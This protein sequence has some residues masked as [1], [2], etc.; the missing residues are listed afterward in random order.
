M[1]RG[2]QGLCRLTVAAPQARGDFAVPLDTPL[3]EALPVLLQHLPGHD[4]ADQRTWILQRLGGRALSM[5]QTPASL[6]LRDGEVLHLRPVDD[7]LSPLDFDDVVDAV[8]TT[9]ASRPDRWRP[10]FSRY[11]LLAMTTCALLAGLV[12][13]VMSDETSMRTAVGLVVAVGLAGG[14]VASVRGFEDTAV[15]AVLAVA[16]MGFAAVGAGSLPAALLGSA[17]GGGPTALAAG[18]AGVV[19][20]VITGPAVARSTIALLPLGTV[21]AATAVAGLLWTIFGVTPGQAG[22]VVGVTAFL[23]WIAAPTAALRLSR[24][25]VPHLP[26][27]AQELQLDIA[28]LPEREAL[29][30]AARADI[31]LAQ[32]SVALGT[33]CLAATVLVL[34][35]PGWPPIVLA[36]VHAAGLLLRS[37][38][39]S[40]MWQRAAALTAGAGTLGVVLV[41]LVDRCPAPWQVALS[42]VPVV[43]AVALLTAVRKLPGRRLL[44]FWGRLA[45]VGETITAVLTMPM[46]AVVLDLYTTIRNLAG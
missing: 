46:L 9:V 2:V 24:L 21:S 14:A 7:P 15:A 34:R 16:G 4:P 8:A 26:G 43:V 29:D 38:A 23:L 28:P 42:A 40:G 18:V 27:S 32:L 11:A 22:A 36:I 19:F 37:R 6:G 5:E 41:T 1:T 13:L 10:E 25:R 20:A 12:G 17:V 39:L 30:R 35:E 45:D 31:I 3:A 33:I 44:P